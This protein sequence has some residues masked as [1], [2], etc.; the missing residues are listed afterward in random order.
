MILNSF[1]KKWKTWSL[2]SKFTVIGTIFTIIGLLISCFFY[3][4]PLNQE[5]YDTNELTHL[6]VNMRIHI[7][8]F[9]RLF[10]SNDNDSKVVGG[11]LRIETW[12][13]SAPGEDLLINVPFPDLIPGEDWIYDVDIFKLKLDSSEFQGMGKNSIIGYILITSDNFHTPLA[14]T[15]YIPKADELPDYNWNK[16][17]LIRF[18][19]R[20]MPRQ[21]IDSIWYEKLANY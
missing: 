1:R 12:I 18:D 9:F 4:L 10:V 21:T 14:W 11:K 7:G 15:F 6:N 8:G 19:Y 3:F 17:E 5:K 16:I 20:S 13:K 2:P